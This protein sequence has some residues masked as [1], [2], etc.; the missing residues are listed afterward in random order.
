MRLFEGGKSVC[1][2]VCF[3]FKEYSITI[4]GGVVVTPDLIISTD[5]PFRKSLDDGS[6]GSIRVA[7]VRKHFGLHNIDDS[8]VKAQFKPLTFDHLSLITD[9]YTTWRDEVE[10]MPIR[11]V[12]LENE[13]RYIPDLNANPEKYLAYLDDHKIKY[14]YHANHVFLDVESYEWEY[15]KSCKRGNDVYIRL[16]REKFKPLVE[17]SKNIDSFFSTKIN[18]NR[19]RIRK[20]RLLYITG[21][22][23]HAV[24]GDIASSWLKFGEYWNTFVTNIRQQF[25]GAE[26]IRAWQSQENGYP[27]F[28]ALIYFPNF[29]FTAM[30]WKKDKSWRVHNRQKLNGKYVRDRL[31][32]AWGF[33]HLDIKCC[34]NTR[35][36]LIDL[37]KYITRDLEGG[38]SNLTNAMVWYFG[39]Q[40]YSISRNFVG[41]L[42]GENVSIGLAEPTNADL[43]NAS[44]VIQRSNSNK[45]LIRLEIFPLINIKNLDFS[46]T[47]SIVDVDHVPDPP[48]NVV[49]YFDK[50]ALSCAAV[51]VKKHFAADGSSFDVVVF[52]YSNEAASKGVGAVTKR[53]IGV[54]CECGAATDKMVLGVWVCKDCLSGG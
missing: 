39:K 45:K 4:Q 46:Y 1:K 35:K 47:K 50:M 52:K 29:E 43:I 9:I 40:S 54:C 34:D 49:G 30:Y 22:C 18:S 48:P 15:W 41:C 53:S 27:H 23:D 13:I 51:S 11:K 38:E 16:L 32:D 26:Y 17:A 8:A 7:L 2:C 42:L 12:Y 19:K 24:T 21:T 31:K 5:D 20:T 10:I 37:L 44:G 14:S 36:A 33:G 28:H 25:E 3:Q 6:E